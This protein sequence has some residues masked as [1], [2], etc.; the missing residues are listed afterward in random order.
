MSQAA[1]STPLPAASPS[2]SAGDSSKPAGVTGYDDKGFT[3]VKTI[4]TPV[5][6]ARL[7][8]AAITNGPA[9][10]AAAAT[11]ASNRVL[12]GTYFTLLSAVLSWVIIAY[13]SESW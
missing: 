12:S 8:N 2:A 1:S 11:N 13:T 6:T 5:S 4:V 10:P 7:Q 9:A 3:T